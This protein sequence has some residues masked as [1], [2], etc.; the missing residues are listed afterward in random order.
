[1]PEN[2]TPYDAGWRLEPKVWVRDGI[3]GREDPRPA[4]PDDYGRVDFEDDEGQSVFTVRF[5]KTEA[6][7][8]LRVDEHQDVV[9]GIETSTQRQVRETAMMQLDADLR[10]IAQK[11]ASSLDFTNDGDPESFGLGHY[12][13]E[14]RAA[15][16]RLALT[17]EY[18]GTDWSDDERVPSAW[19]YDIY[20]L[21][22]DR[23]N[24]PE[25][26]LVTEG[27]I[28]AERVT[29]LTTIVS[30]W[31]NERAREHNTHEAM[32]TPQTQT[33]SHPQGPR[34]AM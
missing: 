20:A 16:H 4:A 17:E 21:A 7:Y 28:E 19:T 2:I 8:I 31:A 26:Q 25:W 23:D 9:L 30:E 13:L 29:E 10:V 5:T 27:R 24:R 1:M 18:D 14:N 22:G 3:T 15:D 12:V 33:P 34:L 11:H 6:G 32:R